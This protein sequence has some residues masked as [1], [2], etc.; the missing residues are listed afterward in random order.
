MLVLTLYT[1]FHPGLRKPD[2]AAEDDLTRGP[3]L[4]PLCPAPGGTGVE[5]LPTVPSKR[6][7]VADRGNGRSCFHGRAERPPTPEYRARDLLGD[8]LL[9]TTR[10]M[11]AS[12]VVGRL[13]G[14]PLPERRRQGRRRRVLT[15]GRRFAERSS[16]CED[17]CVPAPI[18]CRSPEERP[19]ATPGISR[20]DRYAC[21]GEWTQKMRGTASPRMRGRRNPRMEGKPSPGLMDLLSMGIAC[22]GSPSRVGLVGGLLLDNWLQTSPLLTFVGLALGVAAA[23]VLTIR[24][25]RRSL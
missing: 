8:K 7:T 10:P 24:L 22:R 4:G 12:A 3:P 18:R 16:G 6:S 19:A 15:A 25:A 23:V 1:W 5:R 2:P 14:G 17:G 11:L 9:T 21:E 20:V 13:G